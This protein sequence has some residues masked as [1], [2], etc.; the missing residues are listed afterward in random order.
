MLSS[1]RRLSPAVGPRTTTSTSSFSKQLSGFSITK[2]PALFLAVFFVNSCVLWVHWF[3]GMWSEVRHGRRHL[4]IDDTNLVSRVSTSTRLTVCFWLFVTSVS[5]LRWG[6]ATATAMCV[7]IVSQRWVRD[8]IALDVQ[9]TLMHQWYMLVHARARSITSHHFT[10][11][12]LART[13]LIMQ[14]NNH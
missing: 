14:L 2:E 11:V 6:Q 13:T 8:V 5:C 4:C 3:Y 9:F 10:A 12:Q 1:H 7:F